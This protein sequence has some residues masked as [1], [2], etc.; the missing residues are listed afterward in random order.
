MQNSA[1]SA[2]PTRRSLEE[3]A[4]RPPQRPAFQE[5]AIGPPPR[6]QCV[7]S[8]RS[9]WSPVSTSTQSRPPHIVLKI[10]SGYRVPLLLITI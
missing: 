10:A 1:G 5:G 4:K 6:Q 2:L 9:I 7:D 8:L 3:A